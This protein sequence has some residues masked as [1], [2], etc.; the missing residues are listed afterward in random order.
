MGLNVSAVKTKYP[1]GTRVR[2]VNIS[3]NQ[4]IKAGTLGTVT[5]V[6][7]EGLIHINWDN[8]GYLEVSLEK[9]TIL[10]VKKED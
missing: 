2:I 9:D 5:S 10:K 7:E 1:K 3:E 8:G 4:N 6:D